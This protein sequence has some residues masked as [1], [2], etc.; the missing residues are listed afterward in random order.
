LINDG[1]YFIGFDFGMKTIGVA[2]GQLI[3]NTASPLKPLKAKHGI[4]NWPDIDKL[5]ESWPIAGFI[6]GDPLKLDGS[7]Q[8]LTHAARKFA[9]RLNQRYQK[10]L[11]LIDERLTSKE[12][13]SIKK[14]TGD[15]RTNIHSLCAQLILEEW[16]N[17]QNAPN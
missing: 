11:Y 1:R 3:T 14:H 6:V 16:L 17:Q 15:K 10:P 5:L 12:A 2:I 7:V 4:P 8:H 13:A 9:R